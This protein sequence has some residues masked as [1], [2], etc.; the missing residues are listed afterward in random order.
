MRRLRLVR[1]RLDEL[2]G[3]VG[4]EIGHSGWHRIDQAQ[5]R[6]FADATGD[7][8]WL[9][10]DE[11]R[12][13]AGPYGTTIVHGFLTLSLAPLLLGEA[14]ELTG[15]IATV[16]YG[17]DRLRFPAPV[18]AGSRLRAA[19]ELLRLDDVA[20]GVQAVWRLTIEV[21]GGEKPA[22]VAEIV[23]RYLAA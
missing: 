2:A 16:N 13:A 6:A 5:V 23:F 22:C 10:V 8:Q 17:I 21:E 15:C 1:I 18:P 12:A 3:H 19:V 14:V 20:G 4:K 9:H 7:H 11:E